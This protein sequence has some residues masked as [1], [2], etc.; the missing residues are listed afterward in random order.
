MAVKQDV[1]RRIDDRKAAIVASNTST[2]D[3]DAIAGATKRQK[4]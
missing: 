3:I 4:A 1:M 2:L